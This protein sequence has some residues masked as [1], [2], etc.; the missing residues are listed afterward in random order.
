VVLTAG[1]GTSG[2]VSNWGSGFLP[3]HY[4]GV[5][6]RN[7]GDPVLHLSN[8]PGISPALQAESLHAI[9]ELNKERYAYVRDPE[10]MSRISSY[11]LAFRMQTSVPD[12]IRTTD[13]TESTLA[14]YGPQSRIPGTFAANCLLARR[15]VERGVR[16]VQLYH[17]GWDQHYNLPSDLRLQCEDVDQPCAALVQDLKQ[18]G[19]LSTTLVHWGGE[20]GRLPVVE[21]SGDTVG[22][23]HN[24][25]GFSAWFAGGGMKA[26]MTY[27]ETD[28]F[29]HKAVTNV[30]TP[31]D[32]QA[33]LLNL[34]GLDHTKLV[35]HHNG[36]EQKLT[37]NRPA[38]IIQEILA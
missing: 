30:V 8:P 24:G 36:Q 7:Q 13:E 5:L 37:D 1:R 18:R 22:R 16:F 10:I 6:F 17:R 3:S 2:G 25:Q 23:D 21:G 4:Q 14:A 19:L 28:E 29:G 34:F 15:M 12:L 35:Y 11:E 31:N 33:T 9:G 26:G 38:R 20:I 32:Y 27:G